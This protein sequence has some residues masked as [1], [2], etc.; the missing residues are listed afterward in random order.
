MGYCSNLLGYKGIYRDLQGNIKM[1]ELES[2]QSPQKPTPNGTD[3]TSTGGIVPIVTTARQKRLISHIALMEVSVHNL[4]N[5]VGSDNIWEEV[6]ILRG[7]GWIIH[8]IKRPQYDRD[9]RKVQA[10]HYQL[11]TSQIPLAMGIINSA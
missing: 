5:L 10:G 3:C 11:D 4:R 6:R 9:G 1:K 2:Q 7:K 8:T